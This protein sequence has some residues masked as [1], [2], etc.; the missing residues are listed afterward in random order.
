MFTGDSFSIL[1]YDTDFMEL[2][3][4]DLVDIHEAEFDHVSPG[5]VHLSNGIDFESDVMLVNTGWK[6]VPAVQFLPEGIDK[7]LG[8]PHLTSTE[9]VSEEDLANQQDLLEKADKEILTRFPRLKDQ[10]VWNKD[11]VPITETKGID[12]KD[13]VPLPN[14]RHTCC[15]VSSC[16]RPSAFCARE[17]WSLLVPWA[18]SA[19]SSQLTSK[20]S[21]CPHTF[22][23]SYSMIR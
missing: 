9:K 2:V 1:N 15:T 3:K 20:V 17:T 21:G 11:Y 22:K 16:L 6:H 8:I 19:T 18:T 23:V 13:T 10:P 5:K 7:E 4:S 14:S 12:S